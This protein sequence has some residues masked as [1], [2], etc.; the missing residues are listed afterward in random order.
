[1]IPGYEF[2]YALSHEGQVFYVGRTIDV[3]KRF[4]QHL[5]SGKRPKTRVSRYISILIAFGYTPVIKVINYIPAAEA[6]DLEEKLIQSFK[7]AGQDI[8]NGSSFVET[9]YFNIW[10]KWAPRNPSKLVM[11]E[12]INH[13]AKQRV[14]FTKIYLVK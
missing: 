2:V 9:Q 4:D 5:S 3:L 13:M 8:L 7:L 10:P 14:Y 11:R 6:H 12:V 1:M